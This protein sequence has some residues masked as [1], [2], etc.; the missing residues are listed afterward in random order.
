MQAAALC[1]TG[2]VVET[3]MADTCVSLQ[4]HLSVQIYNLLYGPL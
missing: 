2:D 1:S 4:A 3:L